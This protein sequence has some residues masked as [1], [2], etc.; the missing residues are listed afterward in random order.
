[1]LLL[2]PVISNQ[3]CPRPIHAG[4]L[5]DASLTDDSRSAFLPGTLYQGGSSAG[6]IYVE[7]AVHQTRRIR[8]GQFLRPCYPQVTQRYRNK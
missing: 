5:Q 8:Q 6:E 1:M 4:F 7:Q 3:P 2:Q